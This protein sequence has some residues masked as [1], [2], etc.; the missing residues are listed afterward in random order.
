[1]RAHPPPAG[2][3][4]SLRA[5]P[6]R[7]PA[8]AGTRSSAVARGKRGGGGALQQQSGAA[9]HADS[10]QR[11]QA[12]P[13]TQAKQVHMTALMTAACASIWPINPCLKARLPAPGC[14][15]PPPSPA[16]QCLGLKL[17]QGVA[18]AHSPAPGCTCRAPSPATRASSARCAA[19]APARWAAPPPGT[20]PRGERVR[21]NQAYVQPFK[22]GLAVQQG[23][24]ARAPMQRGSSRP[25]LPRPPTCRTWRLAE[26]DGSEVSEPPVTLR[27]GT[28]AATW[29][30]E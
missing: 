10:S 8:R 19:A 7:R 28:G 16:H 5:A 6:A 2:A 3:G 9:K 15:C 26:A 14:A 13:N 4:S 17:S 22:T 21:T 25:G 11:V 27:P 23:V 12:H 30:S 20:R 29:A 1:M 18:P 24:R